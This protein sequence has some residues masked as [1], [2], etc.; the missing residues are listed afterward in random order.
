MNAVSKKYA[1]LAPPQRPTLRPK[2]HFLLFLLI[3]TILGVVAARQGKDFLEL[4]HNGEIQISAQREKQLNQ[5]LKRLNQAEQYVLL[6]KV[7]GW[8][9]CYSC[10]TSD[11]I[12]LFAGEVWR[13]GVTIRGEKGRYGLTLKDK[14]LLYVVEL[15]GNVSACLEAEAIKIYTYPKL[16]EN[17]KRTRPLIRPPGNKVDL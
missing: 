3:C 5:R 12:Y 10:E 4:D 9:P 15:Y 16:P 11:S 13:Y 6:A 17:L 2:G 14:R 1:P 8:Y 7:D